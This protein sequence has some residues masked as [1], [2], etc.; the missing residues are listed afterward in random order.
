VVANEAQGTPGTFGVKVLDCEDHAPADRRTLADV[1]ETAGRR[2]HPRFADLTFVA[3]G[4]VWFAEKEDS[5]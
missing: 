3:A 5:L 4:I 2:T 1:N